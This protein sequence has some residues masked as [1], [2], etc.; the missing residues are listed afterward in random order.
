[1]KRWLLLSL[2]I[3]IAAAA[4]VAIGSWES[5]APRDEA[6]IGARPPHGEIDAESRQ[7]LEQVLREAEGEEVPRR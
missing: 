1:M 2:A 3:A 7:R 4:L 6:Q 5:D